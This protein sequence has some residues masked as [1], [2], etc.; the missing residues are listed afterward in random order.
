VSTA[1]LDPGA[2]W[3]RVDRE[4]S[5]AKWGPDYKSISFDPPPLSALMRL[6]QAL[7]AANII[8]SAGASETTLSANATSPTYAFNIGS[9]IIHV[10][11]GTISSGD[12]Q[13]VRAEQLRIRLETLMA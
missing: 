12:S 2:A 11:P 3:V 4:P 6:K 10:V 5:Y 13:V 7:A 1:P 8:S 9:Y